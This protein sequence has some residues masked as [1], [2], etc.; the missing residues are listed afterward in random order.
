MSSS[1]DRTQGSPLVSVI[2]PFYDVRELLRPCLESVLAQ[3]LD[4][5]EIILV[6]DGSTD[7]SAAVAEAIAAEDPRVRLLTNAT[8]RGMGAAR[9]RGLDEAS[10][11][12]IAFVDA[13]DVLRPNYLSYLHQLLVEYGADLSMCGTAVVDEQG[14]P[15]RSYIQPTSDRG[16]LGGKEALSRILYREGFDATVWAKLFK[17]EVLKDDRFKEGILCEDLELIP[18]LIL[19]ADRVSFCGEPLYLYRRRADS[20]MSSDRSTKGLMVLEE[21]CQ[22]QRARY[23]AD[24]ALGKGFVWRKAQGCYT[25]LE[26]LVRTGGPEHEDDVR[27]L[28]EVIRG[29]LGPVLKDR[30]VRARHKLAFLGATLVPGLF[31]ALVRRK[32]RRSQLGSDGS[33]MDMEGRHDLR[34]VEGEGSE[35]AMS[36]DVCSKRGETVLLIL[37]AGA[38]SRFGGQ[39]KA[40]CQIK[41]SSN[42]L[43]TVELARPWVDRSY[44]AVNQTVYDALHGAAFAGLQDQ[45]P[46]DELAALEA[47][48]CTLFPTLGGG[49]DA[50]SLQAALLQLLERSPQTSRVVLCWGD[51][52]FASGSP[53]R[54]LLYA[55]DRHPLAVAVSQ[56]PQPYAWFDLGPTG[57]VCGAHFAA[58]APPPPAAFHDQ[59]LFLLEPR[60][61]LEQLAKYRDHLGIPAEWAGRPVTPPLLEE[62]PDQHGPPETYPEMKLL[63]AF[64]YWYQIGLVPAQAV[65]IRPGQVLSFNTMTELEAIRQQL[66]QDP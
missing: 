15:V 18:R 59:S 24:P 3:D 39:P 52:V 30:R 28:R 46:A 29:D 5:L 13:D 21:L 66:G 47:A 53:F 58:D 50:F 19:K 55:D 40:L 54:E 60:L 32:T 11:E 20:I 14:R 36:S 44:L 31:A 7:G 64:T 33:E 35:P 63:H 16:C 22:D 57:E 1:P 4:Q 9:N 48:G 12:L 34:S 37:A 2:I 6:D 26:R 61:A 43:R 41:G 8:N 56:D 42:A 38:S 65:E 27:R 51:A 17:K 62:K 25:L 10:C 23:G 49:G 45:G